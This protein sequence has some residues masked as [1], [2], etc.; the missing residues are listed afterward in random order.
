M[1]SIT[2]HSP[3]L[4]MYPPHTHPFF[5]PRSAINEVVGSDLE[6]EFIHKW[7]H[8]LFLASAGLTVLLIYGQLQNNVRDSEMDVLPTYLKPH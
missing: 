4:T 2:P 5:A 7:F 1:P 8:L 3:T 6:F